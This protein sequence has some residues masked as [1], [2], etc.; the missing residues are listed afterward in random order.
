MHI[1]GRKPWAGSAAAPFGLL[2]P[3]FTL[4]FLWAFKRRYQLFSSAFT[5]SSPIH[6]ART[7]AGFS[8]L[9][10]RAPPPPT[11]FP[12]GQ[13]QVHQRSLALLLQPDRIRQGSGPRPRATCALR[14]VPRRPHVPAGC[15]DRPC[16]AAH[17]PTLPSQGVAVPT[18][19]RRGRSP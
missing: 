1:G 19:P 17:S 18:C 2:V 5:G 16:Q 8:S 7:R 11:A 13:L 3:E 6:P 9:S 14:A 4:T 10:T 15:V 12:A